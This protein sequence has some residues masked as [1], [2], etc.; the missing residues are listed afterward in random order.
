MFHSSPLPSW[1]LGCHCE[2][3]AEGSAQPTLINASAAGTE[4]GREETR[5]P[6]TGVS[7]EQQDTWAG[8]EVIGD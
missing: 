1:E 6:R 2:V 3:K 4:D 8:K 7:P 5:V